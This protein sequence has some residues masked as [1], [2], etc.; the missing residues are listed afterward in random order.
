M[1]AKQEIEVY[2]DGSVT[3]DETPFLGAGWVVV[4]GGKTV[5]EG[6][7]ALSNTN[8][9]DNPQWRIDIAEV[10]AATIGL[11]SLEVGSIVRL[12]TD[13]RCVKNFYNDTDYAK[14]VLTEPGI[15]AY[16]QGLRIAFNRHTVLSVEMRHD[17][18]SRKMR[19]AHKLATGASRQ[20]RFGEGNDI[21][22][23]V[24]V[25]PPRLAPDAYDCN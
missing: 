1:T 15:A 10:S 18:E 14:S 19:K 7:S 25:W 8:L 23:D 13:A 5:R 17:F 11:N 21:E 6:S 24:P 2:T 20:Q 3:R 4:M 22:H 16:Y 9:P 12:Y